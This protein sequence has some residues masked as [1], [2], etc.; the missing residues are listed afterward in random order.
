MPRSDAREPKPG[1]TRA[2]LCARCGA[3]FECGIDTGNCWCASLPALDTLPP[4]LPPR[5]LCERCLTALAASNG[6]EP[7]C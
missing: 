2:E 3:R 6:S 7:A 4:G 5:C 1:A